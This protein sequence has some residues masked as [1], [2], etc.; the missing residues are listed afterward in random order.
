VYEFINDEVR[1]KPLDEHAVPIPPG[2]INP[3]TTLFARSTTHLNSISDEKIL[4]VLAHAGL[5]SDYLDE[6]KKNQRTLL[7][8]MD[9]LKPNK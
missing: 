2:T 3:L 4:K 8:E 7:K 6:F 5:S 9:A 1:L